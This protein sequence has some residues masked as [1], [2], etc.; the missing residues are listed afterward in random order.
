M[1]NMLIIGAV[2]AASTAWAQGPPVLQQDTAAFPE[3]RIYLQAPTP[4]YAQSAAKVGLGSGATE[5]QSKAATALEAARAGAED[6]TTLPEVP[7][8]PPTEVDAKFVPFAEQKLPSEG[9]LVVLLVDASASMV[10]APIAR[11]VEATKGLVAKLRP[12]DRVAVLAFSEKTTVVLPPTKD[13]AKA[14]AA[15]EA[16]PLEGQKT[17]IFTAVNEAIGTDLPAMQRTMGADFPS[18]PSRR[19]LFVFSDGR[20]E[21]SRATVEDLLEKLDK[22]AGRGLGLELFTVGVGEATP[23]NKAPHAD[24]ERLGIVAAIG[25][26][27]VDRFFDK[28]APEALAQAFETL[29]KQ[30]AQQVRVDFAMPEAFWQK[31]KMTIELRVM[32]GDSEHPPI[33]IEVARGPLSLAQK[34]AAE[35]YQERLTALVAWHEGWLKEADAATRNRTYLIVGASA[36]MLLLLGV[37]AIRW[38]LTRSDQA[39]QIAL[40]QVDAGVQGQLGELK[41]QVE[42][43]QQKVDQGIGALG[44][45]LKDQQ[46]VALASLHVIEGPMRGKRYALTGR[47]VVVGRETSGQDDISFPPEADRGI[48]RQHAEI[49]ME[50]DGRWAVLCM[51]EGGMGVNGRGVRNGE[52]YGLQV[53]DTLTMGS[54]VLRFEGPV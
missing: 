38:R 8:L 22:L 31:A 2:A 33:S 20:D 37:G 13:G 15:I 32:R 14:V 7:P 27:K 10:D 49:R 26:Y 6:P 1:R 51:A 23:R 52:S 25:P 34:D 4:D 35:A 19:F 28:P 39:Q 44:D 45:R 53:G 24:L 48:S 11:V 30:L 43:Q 46:R 5:A 21:G 18:L 17:L 36:L 50:A 41:K 40:A 12:Q 29:K 16:L 3:V 42:S 47:R 54:S 9:L